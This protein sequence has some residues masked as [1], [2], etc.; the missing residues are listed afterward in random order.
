MLA[1]LFDLVIFDCDGVLVDSE[2][3]TCRVMAA[4]LTEIGLP[5]T[6]ADCARDYVGMWLPDVVAK[7]EAE[8]GGELPDGFTETYRIRQNEALANECELVPGAADALDRVTADVCVASNGPPEKMRITLGRCG[9]LDRFDGRIFSAADVGR[10]KPA[11]DLFLHAAE[12][13]GHDPGRCAVIEDS[14]LGIEAAQAA[15]M[16]AFGYAGH[17][18][19]AALAAAGAATF[20]SMHDVPGLLGSD[21]RRSLTSLGMPAQAFAG[22]ECVCQ[23]RKGICDQSCVRDMLDTPLYI[24][25]LRLS[26]RALPGRRRRRR[27]GSR[28]SRACSPATAT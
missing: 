23:L 9:L 16:A 21:P 7:V 25:C 27:S 14:P 2:P 4:V 15:G 17:A 18:D 1:R 20:D 24:A 19:A 26:G 3:V 22:K 13:M 8:L 5:K 28:R 10:G 12:R 6:T 11:P